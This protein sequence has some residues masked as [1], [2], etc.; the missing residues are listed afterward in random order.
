MGLHKKAKK[1]TMKKAR[2]RVNPE[3]L[4]AIRKK[5]DPLNEGIAVGK[6]IWDT[7]PGVLAA[8]VSGLARGMAPDKMTGAIQYGSTGL[9]TLM[10]MAQARGM[11]GIGGGG[12]GASAGDVAAIAR[13]A[14]MSTQQNQ[15]AANK[16][17][18]TNLKMQAQAVNYQTQ[19]LKGRLESVRGEEALNKAR[20]EKDE[21]EEKYEKAK[22]MSMAYEKLSSKEGKQEHRKEAVNRRVKLVT[23]ENK[24]KNMQELSK[25]DD[26]HADVK[27]EIALQHQLSEQKGN[28]EHRQQVIEK[29]VAI[30]EQ[31]GN[32]KDQ[33]ELAELQNKLNGVTDQIAIQQQMI[34]L[35]KRKQ[36]EG[37]HNSAVIKRK[38]LLAEKSAELERLETIAQAHDDKRKEQNELEKQNI[39]LKMS[40]EDT[41]A[42]T[43][44]LLESITSKHDVEKSERMKQKELLKQEEAAKKR[45]QRAERFKEMLEDQKGFKEGEEF[46]P[47]VKYINEGIENDKSYV[48]EFL[49]ETNVDKLN[50]QLFD[51]MSKYKALEFINETKDSSIHSKWMSDEIQ[52]GADPRE[53]IHQQL[54]SRG[55]I[56]NNRILAEKI[57]GDDGLSWVY[58]YPMTVQQHKNNVLQMIH[59][60]GHLNAKLPDIITVEGHHFAPYQRTWEKDLE[61]FLE[62]FKDRPHI[63]PIYEKHKI[64]EDGYS[65]VWDM[66][67]NNPKSIETQYILNKI[68]GLDYIGDL[69]PKSITSPE[70]TTSIIRM[71]AGHEWMMDDFIKRLPEDMKNYHMYGTID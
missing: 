9:G 44:A 19:S 70:L 4:K 51:Y 31:E 64:N 69:N 47:F 21:A 48:D 67:N 41:T 16:I 22:Q 57:L 65:A 8:R 39:A 25:L 2:K 40:I 30:A 53:V 58:G 36:E 59:E 49:N 11:L 42:D 27:D 26:K 23:E 52:K 37:K 46:E 56:R 45:L 63:A 61:R 33:K 68:V 6:N 50:K 14:Q 43:T 18:E 60:T 32:L 3:V 34:D 7:P 13:M 29:K 20:R 28:T 10:S 54:V 71:K 12:G 1:L 62:D 35:H 15:N 38:Q 66:I 5:N 24:L 55:N 17:E